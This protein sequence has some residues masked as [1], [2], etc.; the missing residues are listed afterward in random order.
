MEPR[1]SSCYLYPAAFPLPLVEEY[2]H[3]ELDDVEE[4]DEAD[5][6]V[7]DGCI[8]RWWCRECRQYRLQ[9]QDWMAYKCSACVS[10]FSTQ[11]LIG[12]VALFKF[13]T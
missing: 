12:S 2:Q 9:H 7:G 1:R 6:F 4:D 10:G 5:A 13:L 11:D 3:H 8:I